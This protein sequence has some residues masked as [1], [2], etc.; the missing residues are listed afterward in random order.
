[1]NTA[2]VKKLSLFAITWPIFIESFLHMFLRTADTF[3]LSKIS[4]DAVA[5][6]GVSNQ[7]VMFMFFLFHVVATGSAIVIAQY[8]GARKY[9]EVSRLTGNAISLNFLFGLLISLGAVIFSGPLLGLFNLQPVHLSQAKIYLL[10]V[11]GALFIQAMMLTISAIIQA[12]GFTRDTMLVTVGMNLLNI[13]GNYLFIYGALGFPQWGVPGV[14]VSTVVSQCLGLGVYFLIL[15]KRVQI[16]LQWLE[17]VKWQKDRIKTILSIGVP[18]SIGH[19]SYSGSQIVTTS[20]IALL[21]AQM[22]TTRIYTQSI[23]FFIMILAI[24][25]G[26]GTQ[27]IIG[28][29]IGAGEKEEAYRQA[30][31]SLKW[32]LLAAVGVTSVIVLFREPLFGL[33]TDDPEII[34]MGGTLLLLGFLLEPGRC[35]N[36]LI[37]QS[38]QAAGDARFMMIVSILVI[39]GFSVPMYYLLGVYLGYGLLGIWAAFIA[40]EWARGFIVYFR[41]K[42]RAWEK[43]AVVQRKETKPQAAG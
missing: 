38:L 22:L 42:S 32:S 8:L 27:I 11:G 7:L 10:I 41:W 40:D 13:F 30:F 23:L 19:L 31:R 20:F 37:G 33:F 34:Y 9:D 5:A 2:Q 39:W 16:N 21:G 25:L 1:M 15:I 14:A 4:D 36:I 17:L 18:S 28:H 6:V 24:S 26:R 35:F 12:H 29:L 43:K 3:M